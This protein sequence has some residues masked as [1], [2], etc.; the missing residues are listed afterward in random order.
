MAIT[1]Y[2]GCGE[3][4]ITCRI[5]KYYGI[6]IT[7]CKHIVAQET[8]TRTCKGIRIDESAGD[9]IVISALQV[10]EPGFSEVAVAVL[11][12]ARIL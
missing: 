12:F 4:R 11:V 1:H 8:L 6:I 5:R 10:V 9:G 2:L 3:E 7:I